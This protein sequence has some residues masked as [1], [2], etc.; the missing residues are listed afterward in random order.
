MA[1]A[2]METKSELTKKEYELVEE[3]YRYDS[4]PKRVAFT[5]SKLRMKIL[6][7]IP[8][9]SLFCVSL[10]YTIRQWKNYDT[11]PSQKLMFAFLCVLCYIL[12]GIVIVFSV[13]MSKD[14][15][16]LYGKT[17]NVRTYGYVN[18]KQEEEILRG[19]IIAL[20]ENI[21][22]LR[23]KLKEELEK[24]SYEERQL[25]QVFMEPEEKDP[26]EMNQEEFFCYALGHYAEDK[27]TVIIKLKNGLYEEEKEKI[28]LRK[29]EL[30]KTIKDIE[31]TRMQ[32]DM[33]YQKSKEEYTYYVLGVLVLIL[34][35][36]VFGGPM[37][38]TIVIAV[39]FI[40]LFSFFIYFF[41]VKHK[42][43]SMKYRVEHAFH[44][45]KYYAQEH[46]IIP[47]RKQKQEVLYQMELCDRRLSYVEQVLSFPFENI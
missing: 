5:K 31:A 17:Q 9:F 10:F 11:D 3:Q 7:L 19:H 36:C 45:V 15:K 20:Q 29:K 42:E 32:I 25:D 8:F 4:I 26:S 12:L 39:S 21:A 23:R 28:L 6:I 47:T 27:A 13:M 35:Q 34:F 24:K 22:S 46:N 30:Q 14:L 43:K 18:F 37:W 40:I 41:F 33:D 16:Q 2:I 44:K 1:S 38:A